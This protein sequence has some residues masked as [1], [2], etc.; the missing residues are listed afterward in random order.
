MLFV[1]ALEQASSR[2]GWDEGSRQDTLVPWVYRAAGGA[3]EHEHA[4][5]TFQRYYHLYREGE[6]EADVA[7][8]GGVVLEGGYERDNWW[9][10]C[11]PE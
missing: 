2:R 5:K 1:W 9:V 8:A 7:A 3:G 4:G 6:L 11:T 10:V